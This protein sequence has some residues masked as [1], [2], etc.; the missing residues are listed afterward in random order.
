FAV[1]PA[2]AQAVSWVPGRNDTLL[3]LFVLIA[4]WSLLK[5]SETRRWQWFL[6]HIIS[7][8]AAFL[9]KET[10][11]IMPAICLIYLALFG[12]GKVP[13]KLVLWLAAGWVLTVTG[14]LL[15]RSRAIRPDLSNVAFNTFGENIAGVVS[16]IGKTVIPVHLSVLPVG[17]DLTIVPGLAAIA[18]LGALWLIAGVGDRKRFWFGSAWFLLLLLP[19]VVR[20]QDFAVFMEQRLYL[21]L[22]GLMLML[23]ESNLWRHDKAPLAIVAVIGLFSLQTI[24]YNATFAS[25]LS[26]W[27]NAAATSPTS[28]FAHRMLAKARSEQGEDEAAKEEYR[29]ALSLD[30][31]DI[32]SY[33]ELGQ[34]YYK[35]GDLREAEHQLRT[36]VAINP[37]HAGIQYN[38]GYF[39]LL[40]GRRPLA[41]QAFLR[42]LAIDP[43]N[44]EL[45]FIMAR[46]Y[47]DQ[48]RY[49]SAACHYDIAL[50]RGHQPNPTL[51]AIL[52][53]YRTGRDR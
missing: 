46:L 40:T 21:P 15:L 16:Y 45:H 12:R 4:V 3:T 52:G 29:Q 50:R 48:Q 13:L 14:Y 37:N 1:H 17:R 18:G 47:V 32:Y 5:V 26:F 2:L 51:E 27:E 38:L 10:A 43:A 9:T 7:L 53:S 25:S 36:A 30:P 42:G 41:Q 49:D 6:A 8:T 11:L 22:F 44:A 33:S 20:S 34:L 31:D 39:Y 35:A 23:L 28:S 19:T 24:R